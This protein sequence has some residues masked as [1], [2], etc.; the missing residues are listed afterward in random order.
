MKV[1]LTLL[2]IFVLSC[3]HNVSED[4]EDDVTVFNDDSNSESLTETFDSSPDT[5]IEEGNENDQIQDEICESDSFE[6][7]IDTDSVSDDNE[8][9]EIDF[10]EDDY[11]NGT[12]NDI[13]EDNEDVD[14][15]DN[16]IYEFPC[17]D[18]TGGKNCDLCVRYVNS[19]NSVN[20]NGLS[21]N[22]AFT[23]I[24][25]AV[26]SAIDAISSGKEKCRIF[27]E[28]GTYSISSSIFLSDKIS[29]TGAFY[30]GNVDPESCDPGKP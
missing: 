29:I 7:V 6:E 30:N 24:Q 8:N 22:T 28:E 16:D 2:F 4:Y 1:V 26:N 9:L 27:I 11:D 17:P 20:K 12:D 19:K 10:F 3:N 18:G 23:S 5:D 14:E 25:N 15:V 21:W 13:D